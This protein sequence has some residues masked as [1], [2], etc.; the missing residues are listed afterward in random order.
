MFFWFPIFFCFDLLIFKK[1]QDFLQ[2]RPGVTDI[3]LITKALVA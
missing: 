2:H 3:L 1:T